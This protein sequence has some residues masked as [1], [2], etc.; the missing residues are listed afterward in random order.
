M[1]DGLQDSREIITTPEQSD[2]GFRAIDLNPDSAS[3]TQGHTDADVF[4]AWV[5]LGIHPPGVT[6]GTLRVPPRI[7]YSPKVRIPPHSFPPRL[8]QNNAFHWHHLSNK[9]LPLPSSQGFS[10]EVA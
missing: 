4:G 8:G 7:T 3:W 5:T 6:Q 10:L 1:G 2:F 9:F